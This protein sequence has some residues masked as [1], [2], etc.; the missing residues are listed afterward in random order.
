[1]SIHNRPLGTGEQFFQLEKY[2][3]IRD[4]IRW[5][6]ICWWCCW[7]TD[8]SSHA[9]QIDDLFPISAI[10]RIALDAAMNCN[11]IVQSR[12]IE[13][14]S[15]AKLCTKTKTQNSWKCEMETVMAANLNVPDRSFS[16]SRIF[17]LLILI[18]ELKQLLCLL[19]APS[20]KCNFTLKFATFFRIQRALA[21]SLTLTHTSYTH[22]HTAHRTHD[23]WHSLVIHVHCEQW[24]LTVCDFHCIDLCVPICGCAVNILTHTH[25]ESKRCAKMQILKNS[26][27]SSRGDGID[28]Y[29]IVHSNWKRFNEK[30]P[31][32]EKK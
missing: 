15:H 23:D 21:L 32:N 13:P 20:G 16:L 30:T 22:M 24:L 9:Y 12:Q 1:M 25:A 27:E 26:D 19:F 8:T 4:A 14:E 7:T 6:F 10:H 28:T 2:Q 3:R 29:R 5:N 31:N 17:L 18:G 11:Q